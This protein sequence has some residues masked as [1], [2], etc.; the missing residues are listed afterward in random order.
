MHVGLVVALNWFKAC[1]LRA[2]VNILFLRPRGLR[3]KT[4]YESKKE[5]Q[6]C[7]Y[8]L[9]TFNFVRRRRLGIFLLGWGVGGGGD[10]PGL[11]P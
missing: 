7:N 4:L 3:N 6:Y 5:V 1:I 2:A 9:Y 8:T 11:P 10:I